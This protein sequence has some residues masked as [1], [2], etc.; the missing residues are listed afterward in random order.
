MKRAAI[1]CLYATTPIL[2]LGVLISF[3][4][5][6]GPTRSN[7]QAPVQSSARA[8]ILSLSARQEAGATMGVSSLSPTQSSLSVARVGVPG[9]VEQAAVTMQV[10]GVTP[11]P[12][13]NA[14][15]ERITAANA[16]GRAVAPSAA[17]PSRPGNRL[18]SPSGEDPNVNV[19][20]P[21]GE[22]VARLSDFVSPS[23][24]SAQPEK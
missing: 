4:W 14:T 15:V 2:S 12:D 3:A 22:G 5:G 20:R 19:L 18:P 16:I 1:V 8:G 24:T 21:A 6:A 7:Q 9:R 17:M 11:K 13:R 23:A 10:Y